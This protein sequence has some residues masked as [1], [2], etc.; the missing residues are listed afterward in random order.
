MGQP[1]YGS[2]LATAVKI[3]A[4]GTYRDIYYKFLSLKKRPLNVYRLVSK[5]SISGYI[6]NPFVTGLAILESWASMPTFH[7]PRSL[8]RLS[9]SFI[10]RGNQGLGKS[11]LSNFLSYFEVVGVVDEKAGLGR[12]AE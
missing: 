2:V 10:M 12:W 9:I 1:E 7:T 3:S 4:G 5:T 6:R 11:L 8:P